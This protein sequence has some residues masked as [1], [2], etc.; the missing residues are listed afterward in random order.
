[1]RMT[2]LI[3]ASAGLLVGLPVGI[4]VGLVIAWGLFIRPK[5]GEPDYSG[6]V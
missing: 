3:S 6:G 1:M 2:V 4:I 5:A